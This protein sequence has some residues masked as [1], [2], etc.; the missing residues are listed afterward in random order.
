MAE[1][2]GP[3]SPCVSFLKEQE[4]DCL[5]CAVRASALFAELDPLDLD[6][7]LKAIHNGV[8]RAETVIYR[9]GDPAEAIFTIRSGMVKLTG[10]T[11]LPSPRIVRLLGRGA[12]I[13]LEAATGGSYEHDAIAMRDLNLCRIP[14]AVLLTL[15]DRHPGLL[16]GLISKWREHVLLSD[17]WISTICNGQQRGRAT[18]LIRL[19]VEISGDPLDAVRLP[20]TADLAAILGCS[21]EGISR[22]MAKLK[23]QGL[24][25][26]VAPRT[27]WCDPALTADLVDRA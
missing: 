1:A 4:S 21:P 18:A 6:Q 10:S 3:Q 24:L 9:S 8:V 14:R 5:N 19:L 2:P 20:R 13:G 12:A 7:R 27:Y 25:K 17:R 26:R 23:R 16:A 11:G 15:G 22:Q